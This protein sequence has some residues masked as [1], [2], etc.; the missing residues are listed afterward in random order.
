MRN[1]SVTGT[2][3]NGPTTTQRPGPARPGTPSILALAQAR[4]TLP[5]LLARE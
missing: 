1:R 5:E 3:Y 4:D 2:F